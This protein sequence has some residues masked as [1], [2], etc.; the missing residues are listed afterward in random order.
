MSFRRI[1]A[2]TLTSL[3]LSQ[4]KSIQSSAKREEY[5][6]SPLPLRMRSSGHDVTNPLL[7]ED[8]IPCHLSPPGIGSLERPNRPMNDTWQ[9]VNRCTYFTARARI[10]SSLLTIDRTRPRSLLHKAIFHQSSL[11]RFNLVSCWTRQLELHPSSISSSQST[12]LSQ[13]V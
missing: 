11:Y 8:S 10:L 4:S 3:S 1:Y 9:L 5:A 6:H 7:R 13:L 2:H 12:K